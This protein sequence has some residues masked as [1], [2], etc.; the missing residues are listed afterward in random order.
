VGAVIRPTH[1]RTVQAFLKYHPFFE[2]F[3]NLRGQCM[4]GSLAGAAAS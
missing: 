3:T 1:K 2:E 4:L